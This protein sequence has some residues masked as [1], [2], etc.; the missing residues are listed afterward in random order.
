MPELPEVETV[1]RQLEPVLV[2]R[3]IAAV[4][5]LDPLLVAPVNPARLRRALVGHAVVGL[6]RRGKYLQVLLDSGDTL[7]MHLRMTGRLHHTA[8]GGR[9]PAD[10]HRRA[11]FTFD[12]G[13]TLDFSDTRRFGRAWMLPDDGHANAAY[14]S[15]RLGPEP[16]DPAFTAE[17]LADALRGRSAPI[18]ATLLDQRRVA[19]IGNIYA[20]E[21][22][23]QARVHPL[24]PAGDLDEHEVA[25]LRDAIVDR[26]HVGIDQGGASIDRYRDT[27]GRPGS[28]QDMLRVHRHEGDPCPVC[29]T[30]IV[31]SRVAQRGTYHCPEC[32]P[33]G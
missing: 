22:L 23:F 13:S 16:L 32:Q 14:W 27:L 1:R 12:D 5:V 29:G 33:V 28:M 11:R 15:A 9:A 30:P 31:K 17:V 19:G 8:P 24:R 7:V 21:A 4:R 26:L 18:K 2:G 3:S 20:D 10:R 25:A 6:G